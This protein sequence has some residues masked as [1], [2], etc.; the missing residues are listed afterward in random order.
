MGTEDL[1]DFGFTA[2][3]EKELNAYQEAERL[4]TEA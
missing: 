3:D 2:V 1:F 4:K